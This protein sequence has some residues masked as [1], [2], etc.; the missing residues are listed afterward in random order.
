MLKSTSFRHFCQKIVKK[1]RAQKKLSL[2]FNRFIL[3][4]FIFIMV[5]FGNT[6]IF[7]QTTLTAKDVSERMQP[8]SDISKSDPTPNGI[9]NI[10][11]EVRPITSIPNA[12]FRRMFLETQ[13]E[14]RLKVFKVLDGNTL[15]VGN[16]KGTQTVRILGIDAPELEQAG[17]NEAKAK[18]LE[19]LSNKSVVLKY[20]TFQ[21]ADKDGVYL[22]RVFLNEKN[23]GQY[24]LEN[25]LA[26]FD[27]EYKYFFSKE[28]AQQNTK[29]QEQARA[30]LIGIWQESNPEKPWK[31]R[32]KKLKEITEAKKKSSNN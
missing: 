23:I 32:E 4:F 14:T 12:D 21:P 11:H 19:L 13:V 3:V 29:A 20:S 9:S 31:Y 18:L 10:R 30:A 26:W 1:L 5:L 6:R 17:G 27:D 25:G 15:Q 24:M 8:S 2:M 16:S 28:E 22:A 7:G